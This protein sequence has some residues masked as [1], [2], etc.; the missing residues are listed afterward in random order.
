MGVSSQPQWGTAQSLGHRPARGYQPPV[1]TCAGGHVFAKTV[2]CF[3]GRDMRL[4]RLVDSPSGFPEGLPLLRKPFPARSGGGV[5]AM[6]R[7]GALDATAGVAQSNKWCLFLQKGADGG[8][9]SHF[10][11]FSPHPPGCCGAAGGGSGLAPTSCLRRQV[12][13]A[14]AVPDTHPPCWEGVNRSGLNRSASRQGSRERAGLGLCPT[15]GCGEHPGRAG[16]EGLTW[17]RG[18]CRRLGTT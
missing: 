10:S 3:P 6:V 5:T 17:Q 8:R 4:P 11:L 15:M 7:V 13:L 16:M 18:A 9:G 1:P 2:P 14:G 12:G